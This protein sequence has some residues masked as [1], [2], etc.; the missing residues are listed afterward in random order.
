MTHPPN[1][2]KGLTMAED[3]AEQLKRIK[4]DDVRSAKKAVD[5]LNNHMK[6]HVHQLLKDTFKDWEKRGFRAFYENPTRILV[7][8]SAK[9]Y[10]EAPKRVV[11]NGE[12]ED[13][14]QTEKYNELLQSAKINPVTQNLDKHSRLLRAAVLLV[15]V[16]R[17][18]QLPMKTEEPVITLDVL[19]RDNCDIKRHPITGDIE[20][21]IY[22]AG[23]VGKQNGQV[24]HIWTNERIIDLEDMG[25]ERY[26]VTGNFENP[27][28]FIPAAILYDTEE[29]TGNPWK[30][31]AW[32]QLISASDGINLFN[33]EALFN[34]SRGMVGQPVTNMSFAK[35]TVMGLDAP[36]LLEGG[37]AEDTFFEYRNPQ[38][39]ITQFLEWLNAFKEQIADEWGVNLNVGGTGSADSGFKLIVE[40]F[41]N[42]ELRQQRIITAKQFEKELFNVFAKMHC[43]LIKQKS[44]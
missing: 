26:E 11:Y 29:T 19:S 21:L 6:P 24:F 2:V 36:I 42:I 28:G 10:K 39:N 32:D 22:S 16:A 40:E 20:S 27:Y 9:T 31:P 23:I 5:Y 12:T 38:V 25:A 41:E 13:T 8:R 34:G 37:G 33:S 15:Q 14:A 1:S 44:G 30:Y 17:P 18:E 3:Y 4:T 43:L 35:G 7:E